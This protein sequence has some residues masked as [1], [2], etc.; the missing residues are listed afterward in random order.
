L[1]LGF[2]LGVQLNAVTYLVSRHFGMLH[3]GVL[4]GIVVG[5]LSIATGTGPLLISFVYDRTNT[6]AGV[7]WGFIPVCLL[8]AILF[9]SLGR[10]PVFD[11]PVATTSPS[12]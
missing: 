5:L 9:A 7:L 2:S 6:Y 8:T 1:V 11:A 10:Y 3:Y 4:F 12:N